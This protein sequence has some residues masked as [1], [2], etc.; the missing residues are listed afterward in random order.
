MTMTTVEDRRDEF[1]KNIT[2]LKLDKG[3][4]GGD[5]KTLFG[6]L[7]L[8]IVG[9]VGAFVLYISSLTESDLRNIASYQILAIAFLALT[10][11]GAAMFI[12]ASVAKVLRLWLV[13]QLLEGQAQTDQIAQALNTRI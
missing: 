9:V 10:V 12:A 13:R 6:G 5:A 4:S 8:M 11:I 3:Q 2:D 1:K 7:I